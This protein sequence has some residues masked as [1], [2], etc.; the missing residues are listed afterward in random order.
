MPHI[1]D[2]SLRS[3]GGLGASVLD[4]PPPSPVLERDP[5]RPPTTL[6]EL[7]G[8]Q[9][10]SDQL[11]EPVLRGLMDVGQQMAASLDAM[12]QAAPN[13]STD[14]LLVKTALQRLL[15][16]LLESGAPAT[17]PTAAGAGFPAGGLVGSGPAAP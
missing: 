13:L 16:R 17:S 11:P 4:A 8:P 3:P 14:V 1:G 7:A 6:A 2:P 9:V 15:A 10:S 5:Q 12:A